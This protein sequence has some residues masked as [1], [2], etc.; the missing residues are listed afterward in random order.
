MK[1]PKRMKT[2]KKKPFEQKYETVLNNLK[3]KEI[4]TQEQYNKLLVPLKKPMT[5]EILV[6]KLVQ[7]GVINPSEPLD[8]SFK[9]FKDDLGSLNAGGLV[10]LVNALRI[11]KKG[12]KE[13]TPIPAKA[14]PI[15]ANI[16]FMVI[17]GLALF[18]VIVFPN[19]A[20]IEKGLGMVTPGGAGS[21]PLGALTGML[22]IGGKH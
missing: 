4:I 10:L 22:R 12:L 16:L 17:I 8:E 1:F 3:N 15:P 11:D 14:F 7:M 21:N 6:E 13:M 2:L 5:Q 19:L 9:D 18:I 20:S